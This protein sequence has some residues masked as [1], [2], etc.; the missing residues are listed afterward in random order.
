M[1]SVIFNL[2]IWLCLILSGCVSEKTENQLPFL[3][4]SAKSSYNMPVERFD[5]DNEKNKGF[6]YFAL[7]RPASGRWVFIFDPNYGAWAAYNESGT[8]VNTGRASGGKD[9][10][11]DVDRPCRTTVGRFRILRKGD[12]DCESSIY[13]IETNG[14]APMPY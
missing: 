14:G 10:C 8:L 9:F 11:P 4:T 7:K 2:F 1:I 6:G 13:P 3:L 5:A 12:A